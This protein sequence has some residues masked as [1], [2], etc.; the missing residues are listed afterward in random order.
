MTGAF[1]A[2]LTAFLVVNANYLPEQSPEILYWLL[3]T[4][5]FTPLIIIW[6]RK[7]EVKK[8]NTNN[9]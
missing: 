7:F 3:P 2:A 5:V 1:I 6:R 9:I 4:I 8:I